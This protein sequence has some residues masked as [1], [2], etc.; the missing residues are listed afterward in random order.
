MLENELGFITYKLGQDYI[1]IVDIYVLPEYRQ[2]RVA[3]DLA[4]VVADKA[5]SMGKKRLIGTIDL[6]TNGK[7]ESAKAILGY[8]FK[9]DSSDGKM[10]YFTKEIR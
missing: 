5:K 8:G 4:D 9:I 10:I 7:T 3:S 1:Y 6:E 2:L